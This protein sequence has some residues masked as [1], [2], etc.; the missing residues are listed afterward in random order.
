QLLDAVAIGQLTP[1]PV[2][3]TTA[4]VGYIIAGFPGAIVATLGIFLPSFVL[5][6]LTAPLIPRMRKSTFLGAF[7]AGVNAGVIAA[8]LV[9]L[10]DL[11]NAALRVLGGTV[12]SPLAIGLAMAALV[13]LIRYK[14]N[15]TWL[16][17]GGGLIGLI[18]GLV[19]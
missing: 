9:T 3:T 6:I 2:S 5:V 11:A 10:L 16:I 4:V 12:W 7:L 18:V 14:I 15:A 19:S 17:A 1:G 13:L 8:I